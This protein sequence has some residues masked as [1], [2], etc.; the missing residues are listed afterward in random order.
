ML[1]FG[2]LLLIVALAAGCT[3]AT[4]SDDLQTRFIGMHADDFFFQW[5]A[6]VSSKTHHHGGRNYLWMSGRDSE[7]EPG[8]EGT[9]DLI[10]NTAW[11]RGYRVEAYQPQ[12][13]CRVDIVTAPNGIITAIR[14]HPGNADWWDVRRCR[15]VF[16][17]RSYR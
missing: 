2:S 6:P 13:E 10:G 7:Y 9:V 15:E 14:A 4:V 1:R 17:V 8:Y 16:G 3:T 12:L 11:W 5:G